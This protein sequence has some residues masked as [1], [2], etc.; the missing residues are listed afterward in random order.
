MP[1]I[2]IGTGIVFFYAVTPVVRENF[3]IGLPKAGKW[4]EILNSDNK[5]YGGSGVG[6]KDIIQSN[7][8]S[9]HH[10]PYS[11]NITLPPLAV[12]VFEQIG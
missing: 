4:R 12:I 3:N 10:K 9:T 11:L 8:F 5:K 1:K 7:D 2:I 6:N